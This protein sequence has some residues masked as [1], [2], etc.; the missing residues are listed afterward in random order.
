MP[1]LSGGSFPRQQ[2][3]QVETGE[4]HGDRAHRR[5]GN[6]SMPGLNTSPMFWPI[7]VLGRIRHLLRTY[8]AFRGSNIP[9]LPTDTS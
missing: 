7:N 5:P 4:A 3:H 2:P 1:G 9:P 8:A 6:T